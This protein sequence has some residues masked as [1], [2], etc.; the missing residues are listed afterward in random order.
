MKK[1]SIHLSIVIA[2]LGLLTGCSTPEPTLTPTPEPPPAQA[3]LKITGQVEKELGWTE[4]EIRAMEA[5]EAEST[6]K[7]GETSTYTGVPLKDLLELA[8][9][10]SDATSLVFVADDGYTAQTA[11]AEVRACQ[12]CIVS[13]RNQG[14]FSIVMPGFPGNVQVKGVIEMQVK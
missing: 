13:L 10:K 12:D 6:N 4:E 5:I 14:G 9:V 2:L 1:T 7:K 3:A 11:L 8:G